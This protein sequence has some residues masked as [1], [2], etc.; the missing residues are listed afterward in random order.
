MNKSEDRQIDDRSQDEQIDLK[1]NGHINRSTETW[2]DRQ[3]GWKTSR[4]THTL[5]H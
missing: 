3:R 1:I 2:I 4:Q 5:P